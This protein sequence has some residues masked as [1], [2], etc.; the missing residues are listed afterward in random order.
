M[1]RSLVLESLRLHILG[2]EGACPRAGCIPLGIADIDRALPAGGIANGALH[3]IAGSPALADDAAATVFLAGILAQTEGSVIWC[4]R[5]RELFA[6]ALYLAGLHPDRVIF[7]EAGNDAG[8]LCAMEEALRHSGLGGVVGELKKLG[9]TPSKRLQLAAEKSGVPA[10][11]FRRWSPLDLQTTGSAAMTRWR[12][13]AAPSEILDIASIGRPRWHLD[14]E[15]VR[16][17]E[18]KSWIVEA[19]DAQGRIALPAGLADRPA[20]AEERQAAA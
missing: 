3:E 15:R 10:F 7:V 20:P 4:L 2:I 6:P 12:V 14:L 11:V 8:I 13:R 18:P 5:W 17:G 9:T 16:G 19:A 1:N